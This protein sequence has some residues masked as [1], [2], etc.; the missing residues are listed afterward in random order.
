MKISKSPKVS[1]IIPN[2]NRDYCLERTIQSVVD[3]TF[4]DWEMIIVD[5]NSTDKSL[6][7]ISSFEDP[8]ISVVQ[9]SNGGII[10]HSRNIG[11]REARGEYIAFLDSDDWWDH[12]KLQESIA[13]LDTGTDLVYHDLY[14]ISRLPVN[15]NTKSIVRT[16]PVASPVIDDLLTNGNA[17][18]NS[19]VVVR[20]SLM[21]EING[22]SE[23]RELVG[24]EDFDGWIRMAKLTDKF[25]RLDLVLGYYWNGGG[26]ATSSR[27]A[28]SN[29]I[30]LSYR[31]ENELQNLFGEELP[32]WMLYSLAR[33][34]VALGKFAD[35]RRYALLSIKSKLP[36][37]VKAK[38][39]IVWLMSLVN[40]RG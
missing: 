12:A 9:T 36:N 20:S 22:F 34:S 5:N 31:Y 35:G 3:Q 21:R 33:S 17:I 32:G 4:K 24:S 25:D 37:S 6:E 26:N 27:T 23:Q 7:V 13:C 29:N 40:F 8:R 10:A 15:I 38:A 30:F 2:F 28:L 11:I 39:G 1:V 14:K 18:N 19:S 16:R